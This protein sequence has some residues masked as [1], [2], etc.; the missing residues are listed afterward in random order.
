L[1]SIKL[2]LTGNR[3][4]QGAYIYDSS[5]RAILDFTSGHQTGLEAVKA[6]HESI[7]DI[8]GRGLLRGMEIVLDRGKKIPAPE[9]GHRVGNKVK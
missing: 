1:N 6:R 4:A 3:R 7:G 5:G 9:L 8:R 2:C